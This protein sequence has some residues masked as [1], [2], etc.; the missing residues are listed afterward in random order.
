MFQYFRLSC[1]EYTCT[2]CC[3]ALNLDNN[4]GTL[5]NT[6]VIRSIKYFILDML[7]Y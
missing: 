4:N 6:V 3:C 5:M 1:Y 7:N 2:L